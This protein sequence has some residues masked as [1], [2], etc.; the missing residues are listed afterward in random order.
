L[1]AGGT[2]SARVSTESRHAVSA[3]GSHGPSR[4]DS[5]GGAGTLTRGARLSDYASRIRSSTNAARL[6]RGTPA[7]SHPEGLS[8]DEA[9]AFSNSQGASSPTRRALTP[10]SKAWD[11]ALNR[12]EACRTPVLTP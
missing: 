8:Q 9:D 3:P 6:T 2:A 4:M 1:D 12:R 7:R 10:R 5:R 11:E